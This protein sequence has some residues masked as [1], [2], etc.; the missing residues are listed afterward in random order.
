VSRNLLFY[1]AAIGVALFLIGIHQLSTGTGDSGLLAAA[2]AYDQYGYNRIVREFG[3]TGEN[4]C[5]ARGVT[6]DCLN[7]FGKSTYRI[8][9]NG[10]WD[11]GNK[12]AWVRTPYNAEV[13]VTVDGEVYTVRWVGSCYEGE[14][15]PTGGTCVWGEYAAVAENGSDIYTGPFGAWVTHATPGKL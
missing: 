11:R 8:R 13:V 2:G 10:E 14:Y 12:E 1:G 6:K 9:W 7:E 4:W 5:L 3:G 15:L